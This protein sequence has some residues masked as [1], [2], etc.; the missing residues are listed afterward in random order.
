VSAK[1]FDGKALVNKITRRIKREAASL[2]KRH[3]IEVGLGILLITGDQVSMADTGK[4]TDLATEAGIKIHTER[5]A[6][7]NVARKFYPTLDEYASSPFIQGIFIQLPL[8]IDVV[9][10]SEVMKRLPPNKDVACLHFINRG[11]STYPPHEVEQHVKPPEIL[12]VVE[13][14]KENDFELQGGKIVLIGSNATSS[15]VKMLAGYLYDHGCNVRLLR[16]SS[17]ARDMEEGGKIRRLD[18]AENIDDDYKSIINPDGEAVI[19]WANHPGWLTR[20]RLKPKSIIIDLGYKFARGKISGDCD[21]MSVS[22]GAKIITPV[23]GGVKNI[24]QVMVLQNLMEL[25]K[26][27][28]SEK[29]GGTKASLKRRF[30]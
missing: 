10:M 13:T 25:I 26:V 14:L 23:P 18:P 28:L 29:E 21:F 20:Q 22:T 27:Q 30:T 5:V 11:I 3:H 8:P 7:R 9:P 16:Y 24:A 6:K 19:S 4:I 12:A 15:M 17:I 2:R 1:V